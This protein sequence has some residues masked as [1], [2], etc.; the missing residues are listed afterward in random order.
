MTILAL[1]HHTGIRLAEVGFLL[2]VFGGLWLAASRIPGFKLGETRTFIAGVAVAIGAV[3]IL[4]AI[5]WAHF[6]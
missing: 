6:A 4:I 2:F 5:H 3:L 1:T